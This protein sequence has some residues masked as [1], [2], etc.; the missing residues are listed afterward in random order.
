M[1]KQSKGP[2]TAVKGHED[3]GVEDAEGNTLIYP[4]IPYETSGLSKADAYLI[5]AAP[6]MLAALKLCREELERCKAHNI[7]VSELALGL[8]E[9]AIQ[10]AEGK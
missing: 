3:Y 2:W 7:G 8:S 1:S 9:Q 5:A 6:E 4:T 10:N